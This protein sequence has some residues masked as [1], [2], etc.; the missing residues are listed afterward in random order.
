MTSHKKMAVAEAESIALN[1]FSCLARAGERLGRF[2]DS[3]GLRPET[4]RIAAGEPGFLAAVLDHVAA[5][6]MLLIDIA[7]ELGAKP[8]HIMAARSILSPPEVLE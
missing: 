6:E 7:K 3:T 2:L 5:D 1:A 8:E 4:I